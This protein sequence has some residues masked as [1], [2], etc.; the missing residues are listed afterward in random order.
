MKFRAKAMGLVWKRWSKV[1]CASDRKQRLPEIARPPQAC[2]PFLFRDTIRSEGSDLEQPLLPEAQQLPPPRRT[3][4]FRKHPVPRRNATAIVPRI[5]LF[6]EDLSNRD[7]PES[8]NPSFDE[9][10]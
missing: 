1:V 4:E 8:S 7:R 6:E 9:K 10:K 2:I 5:N 3:L